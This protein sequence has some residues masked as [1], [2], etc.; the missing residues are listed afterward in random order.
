[1][2]DACYRIKCVR[3]GGHVLSGYGQQ[4]F[5]EGEEVDLL[6]ATTPDAL[7]AASWAVADSMCRDPANEL[8]QAIAAGHF[9]VTAA[10]PV[11]EL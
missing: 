11:E 2:I 10:V 7:R 5:A 9:V 8:A 4:A 6:A 3:A 1:M